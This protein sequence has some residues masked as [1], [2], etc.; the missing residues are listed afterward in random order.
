MR[1]LLT[2]YTMFGHDMRTYTIGYNWTLIYFFY[3]PSVLSIQTCGKELLKKKK[4]V[5]NVFPILLVN[6]LIGKNKT[7]KSQS[8][9]AYFVTIFIRYTH[10]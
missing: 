3:K 4:N 9:D 2:V 8:S 5:L 10:R 6:L 1:G 7:I